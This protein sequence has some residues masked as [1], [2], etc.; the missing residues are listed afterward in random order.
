[1]LHNHAQLAQHLC[2]HQWERLPP[3]AASGNR[4][5]WTPLPYTSA[6][7][8]PHLERYAPGSRRAIGREPPRAATER[9][10]RAA[11]CAALVPGHQQP[12]EQPDGQQEEQ[13]PDDAEPEGA[14]L[15]V[16]GQ[17]PGRPPRGEGICSASE[18]YWRGYLGRV[19]ARSQAMMSS[20]ECSEIGGNGSKSGGA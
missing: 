16:L 11:W 20:G 14:A 1:M 2:L 3:A 5:P 9:G 4:L 12:H 10:R 8:R 18:E 13:Q 19:E 7:S 17:G 15:T 6:H